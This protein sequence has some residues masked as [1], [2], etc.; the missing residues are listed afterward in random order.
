MRLMQR[1]LWGMEFFIGGLALCGVLA[2]ASA[3]W[4]ER[5]MNERFASTRPLTHLCSRVS[6]TAQPNDRLELLL[7]D[8]QLEAASRLWADMHAEV[9]CALRQAPR[10]GLAVQDHD[11]ALALIQRSVHWVRAYPTWGAELANRA[12]RWQPREPILKAW[13]HG[14]A[15]DRRTQ[16][17]Q[18]LLLLDAREL[19]AV[20]AA[21]ADWLRALRLPAAE[22]SAFLARQPGA[23]QWA[24]KP[25][26]LVVQRR[27]PAQ[28]VESG[29]P[30][31]QTLELPL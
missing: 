30:E 24:L 12:V 16:A 31:F 7:R 21:F 8:G 14:Q 10:A 19:D 17:Q 25:E 20:Q 29:L 11:L 4:R 22:R 1:P 23:D 27:R 18:Q 28:F 15:V 26:R 2:L 6:L 9:A 3:A 13:F 5:D